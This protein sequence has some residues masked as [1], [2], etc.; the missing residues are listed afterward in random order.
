SA[1]QLLLARWSNRTDI[2]VGTPV[3]CRTQPDLADL[4]GLFANTLVL[5]TDLGGNPGFRDLF[6]R[7]RATVFEALA[8]Q[9]APFEKVVQ[10]LSAARTG[11]NPL[12]QVMFVFDDTPPGDWTLPGLTA[13]IGE[14]PGRAAKF[15]LLVSLRAEAGGYT[16]YLE[17]DPAV[18]APA[19]IQR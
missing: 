13:Q 17:A 14:A 5:R 6:L 12:F 18:F 9:E 4:I 3:A 8:N 10:A 16:G 11:R 15:D 19:T 1:F 2:A 7:N